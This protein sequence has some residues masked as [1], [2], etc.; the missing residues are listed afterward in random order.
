MIIHDWDVIKQL[1]Y[2]CRCATKL[3]RNINQ[4]W[5]SDCTGI[6]QHCLAN[7]AVRCQ[8]WL[9][10]TELR[11]MLWD[12]HYDLEKTVDFVRVSRIQIQTAWPKRSKCTKRRQLHSA[13]AGNLH[14]VEKYM[15]YK[16]WSLYAQ[17]GKAARFCI[18]NLHKSR[19]LTHGSWQTTS[20]SLQH[21]CHKFATD[22][23]FPKIKMP[24]GYWLFFLA[25]RL[26]HS[27]LLHT[28]RN[29]IWQ[30]ILIFVFM[31]R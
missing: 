12:C 11:D 5:D 18:H 30:K 25:L 26:Q 6:L 28:Q 1:H 24:L 17:N 14:Q 23:F 21:W 3:L 20:R 9:K 29:T 10:G 31:Y 7:N 4:T 8:S 27:T 22:Q 19:P 16:S 15:L 2:T 13:L